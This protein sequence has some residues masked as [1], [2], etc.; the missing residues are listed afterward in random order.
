MGGQHSIGGTRE[1]QGHT[2]MAHICFFLSSKSG[3]LLTSNHNPKDRQTYR[4]IREAT[5]ITDIKT[6][7]WEHDFGNSKQKFICSH[8]LLEL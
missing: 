5:F 8:T 1:N 6:E 2:I 4:R 7:F 3:F